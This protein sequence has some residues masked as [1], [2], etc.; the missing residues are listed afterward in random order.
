MELPFADSV[1]GYF[2]FPTDNARRLLP[3][4]LEPFEMHHGSSVLSMTVF[5]MPKSPVGAYRSVVMAVVVVPYVKGGPDDRLPKGAVY[6]YL[7]ATTAFLPRQ[8]GGSMFHLPHWGDNVKI[9]LAREGKSIT[10]T[11]AAG[12]DPVAELTISEYHWEPADYLYQSF[13]KDSS[14]TYRAEVLVKG[15]ISEHEE[16]T[17]KLVLHEHELHKGLDIADVFEVPIREIWTRNA[18]QIFQPLVQIQKA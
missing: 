16:E 17:G 10:A 12:K 14:G 2:E 4:H 3:P 5:D 9:D 18:V 7:T 6:P 8:I 1:S 15:E 13:M 11:V